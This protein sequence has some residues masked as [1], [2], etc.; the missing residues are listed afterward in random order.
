MDQ[1]SLSNALTFP[2]ADRLRSVR[3]ALQ[4]EPAAWLFVAKAML[5]MYLACGLAMALELPS[6]SMSM[7]TVLVVMNSQ[8][9]MVMAKSFYRITGTL[10]GVT[11][12]VVIVALFPQQPVLMLTAIALWSGMCAAGA[13]MLRGFRGYTFVLGGYTVAMIVLP[14]VNNPA[15]IF[16]VAVHRFIEV[17]LGLGVTTLVFDGLFPNQLAGQVKKRAAGN[18]QYLLTEV[19]SGLSSQSSPQDQLHLDSARKAAVFDD[20]LANAVFEGPWLSSISRPLKRSNHYFMQ[21]ITRLQAFR[22]LQLRLQTRLPQAADS[23]QQLAVPILT[24]LN[25]DCHDSSRLITDLQQLTPALEHQT[26]PLRRSLDEDA[27]Q[28]FDTGAALLKQMLKSLIRCLYTLSTARPSHSRRQLPRTRFTRVYDPVLVLITMARTSFVTF[29]VG[30]LWIASG[31]SSGATGL[32]IVVAL[33]MMLA[34]LPNPVAAVR[35]AA[36]GHTVAPF[37]ALICFSILPSLT[38]YPL[39]IIGTAP[40]LM[41]ML[42]IVT[43]PGWAGF[44]VP[45]NFGFMV[46]LNIGHQPGTDYTFFFNEMFAA[47]AGV[48]LALGGFMLFPGVNGTPG[49]FR[50]FMGFLDDSVRMAATAPLPGLAERIESRNRD[51]SVQMA[52]Q[53]PPGSE[54]TQP[55]LQRSL[56][57]QEAC[58]VLLALREDLTSPDIAGPQKALISNLISVISRFWQE[59]DMSPA[60]HARLDVALAL[61]LQDLSHSA[62]LQPL[63]EHLYLLAD[64]LDE[65][66]S[67][68]GRDPHQ[69]EIAVAH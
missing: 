6:P 57:T 24:R 44:A 10:L 8:S 5:S 43:R 63:R 25:A 35:L 40:F 60:G 45:L 32:F 62:A 67:L 20:L 36:A 46:A 56:L 69:K 28:A 47:I 55:F 49:Q 16:D 1:S 12:S 2:G 66:H 48:S 11:A 3:Q 27:R 14:V 42:Y 38:T 51:I 53:L 61:A 50:R 41:T 23:L 17:L 65:Q 64:V 34:P 39:L 13:L 54:H 52:S 31:W 30:L 7:L 29:S 26:G 22:R 21:T 18:L 15:A 58:Y 33:S 59:G 37:I 19:R 68:A 4:G 9:G